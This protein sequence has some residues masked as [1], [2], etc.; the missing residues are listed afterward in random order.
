MFVAP[1][2]TFLVRMCGTLLRYARGRKRF[3]RVVQALD[4][5]NVFDVGARIGTARHDSTLR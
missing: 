1:I 4:I 3:G 5:M 2:H